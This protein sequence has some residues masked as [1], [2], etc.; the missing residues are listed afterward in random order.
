MFLSL[1]SL[2]AY[3]LNMYYV[4]QAFGLVIKRLCLG[5]LCPMLECLN[6]ST[7]S[8]D[9]AKVHPGRQKMMTQVIGFWP[10]TWEMIEFLAL[11]F[12]LAQFWP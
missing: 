3:H 7:H 12:A 11:G 4:G 10:P 2:N 1:G 5:H 8:P 9:P 6:L